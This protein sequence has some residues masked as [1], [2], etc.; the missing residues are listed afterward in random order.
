MEL[1]TLISG[2]FIVCIYIF[3]RIN[4]CQDSEKNIAREQN[5]TKHENL[6]K[7]R[8]E[9]MTTWGDGCFTKTNHYVKFIIKYLCNKL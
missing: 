3:F 5:V 7:E 2:L 8:R 9:R 6:Q 4:H 1:Y